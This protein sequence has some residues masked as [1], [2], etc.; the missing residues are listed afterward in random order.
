VDKTRF[1]CPLGSIIVQKLVSFGR[2]VS[3]EN[4]ILDREIDNPLN[5]ESRIVILIINRPAKAGFVVR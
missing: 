5:F 2:S 4:R 1:S 3:P